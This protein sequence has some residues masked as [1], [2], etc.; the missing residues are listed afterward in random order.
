M[1]VPL[2]LL[3][4]NMQETSLYEQGRLFY[5]HLSRA[6]LM[7]ADDRIA[8]VK[9]QCEQQIVRTLML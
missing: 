4:H 6:V 5:L 9:V 7:F 3:R 8:N 1:S 2:L